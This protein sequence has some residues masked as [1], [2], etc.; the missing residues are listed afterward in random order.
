MN[1]QI[2]NQLALQSLVE[3]ISSADFLSQ[4]SLSLE[5][6]QLKQKKIRILS[7]GLSKAQ[8]LL[9]M[10]LFLGRNSINEIP[11]LCAPK[12]L[13]KLLLS[14]EGNNIGDTGV[15]NIVSS[16]NKLNLVDLVLN[17]Q[18]NQ[19][20]DVGVHKIERFIRQ[21][22]NKLSM[23]DL[24][25]RNNPISYSAALSLCKAVR[26]SKSLNIF[27]VSWVQLKTKEQRNKIYLELLKSAHLVFF[28]SFF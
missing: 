20:T 12:N 13:S 26:S 11:W 3:L 16:V 21:I 6:A 5:N 22:D 27:L 1:D 28:K 15:E 25:L 18:D 4:L 23:L 19:I 24:Q 2:L 9:E 17:L 14:I 7:K 10:K 8:N